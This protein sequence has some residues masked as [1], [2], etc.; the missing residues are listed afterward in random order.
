MGGLL[1][2]QQQQQQLG[3][4]HESPAFSA[5]TS[6]SKKAAQVGA[7]SGISRVDQEPNFSG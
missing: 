4:S 5:V 2:K 1:N 7:I 6:S 3:V